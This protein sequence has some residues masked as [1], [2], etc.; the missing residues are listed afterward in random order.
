MR[1]CTLCLRSVHLPLRWLHPAEGSFLGLR[2]TDRVGVK[3]FRVGRPWGFGRGATIWDFRERVHRSEENLESAG[4]PG[5]GSEL[6]WF[7][8]DYEENKG[9]G[10]CGRN[11]KEAPLSSVVSGASGNLFGVSGKSGQAL[12]ACPLCGC[13]RVLQVK[14]ATVAA[15]G[16]PYRPQHTGTLQCPVHT[17]MGGWPAGW[18]NGGG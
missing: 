17:Q 12:E 9:W 18:L 6:G 3:N 2:G 10:A 8:V 13:F 15:F 4:Q 5:E 16:K 14:S 11:K 7:L 1:R